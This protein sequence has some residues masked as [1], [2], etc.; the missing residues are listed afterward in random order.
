MAQHYGANG[1]HMPFDAQQRTCHSFLI[2]NESTQVH[3]I[4]RKQ[5]TN[6]NGET[7]C[8][9]TGLHHLKNIYVMKQYQD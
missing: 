6:L 7:V 4:M 2:P 8:K 9:L 5:R 3:Q 1:H